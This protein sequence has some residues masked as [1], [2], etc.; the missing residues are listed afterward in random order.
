MRVHEL[1]AILALAAGCGAG[2]DLALPPPVSVELDAFSG[3]PNPVWRLSDEEVAEVRR[4][5]RGLARSPQVMPDWGLGYRGFILHSAAPVVYVSG[6][7]I[8]VG[9]A[10]QEAVYYQDAHALEGWLLEL[11]RKR[12]FGRRSP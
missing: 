10:D 1:A 6:G 8:R 2:A 9:E 12:G 3:R 4:R 11:A 5:T 7:L